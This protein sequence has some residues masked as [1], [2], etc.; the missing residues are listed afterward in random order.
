MLLTIPELL[1][2]INPKVVKQP[3]ATACPVCFDKQGLQLDVREPEEAQANPIKGSVNIPRGVLEMK[4]LAN[5]PDENLPIFIHCATSAR[6]TL[7]A[8]QLLRIGYKDITVISCDLET[9]AAEA[10]KIGSSC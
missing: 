1:A 10:N 8:E 4:M 6:A 5:Y 3:A 2:D 7:A 9:I